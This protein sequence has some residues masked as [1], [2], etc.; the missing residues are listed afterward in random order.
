MMGKHRGKPN[1]IRYYCLEA[2]PLLAVITVT[3]LV[4][5]IGLAAS[6]WF[7]GQLVQR[8]L[9]I[10]QNQTP[11]NRM[12]PLAAA[13]ALT[14][15]FVQFTRFLKRLFVRKFANHINRSMKM[16][17]YRSLIRTSKAELSNQSVGAALTKSIA[18][19]DT[20]VEGIRKFTTE[21]FD[22]GIAFLTYFVMLMVYD[23][24]L[25]LIS[26]V[27]PPV[28]WFLAESM[29]HLASSAASAYKESTTALN[30]AT[31]DRIENAITYRV[32]GQDENRNRIYEGDLEDYER[33]AA[34]SGIL[35][36]SLQPVY[37][38]IA[39]LGAL[40]ILWLGGKNVAGTG[41][42]TWDIAAFTA[43]LSCFTKLSVK[44]SKIAKL[45]NSVQKARVSWKRVQP[46]LEDSEE[47]PKRPA[48]PAGDLEVRKLRFA[49]P[50]CDPLFGPVSFT[51]HP[52]QII[53]VT[54][55]VACGKSTLG[56]VFLCEYPY[57][58]AVLFGG[59]ELSRLIRE[60][61]GVVGYVGHDP[62]LLQDSIGENILLGEEGSAE[63][64][65]EAVC[66]LDEVLGMPQGLNTPMGS[67]REGLSGGQQ[68]RLA[69]ARALC[70]KR[71]LLIL[72]DPFSAVDQKTERI[73]FDNL[74]S[75]LP[76]TI[77]I[78]ISHRLSLFP[79]MDQV[80]WMDEGKIEVSTHE[81]LLDRNEKYAALFRA[82]TGKEAA[83]G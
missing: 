36:T 3:G 54:G 28:A 16:R 4:Y 67:S 30:N 80:L 44:S 57:E 47:I 1:T 64:Y 8:L 19:V 38:S 26:M 10:M 66:M 7:E 69:L 59:E 34:R 18:D 73:I 24:K 9:D 31:M 39:M 14:V 33:K 55:P 74:R 25:A 49:Y 77:I 83:V 5:N 45:F 23:W 48:E 22:T 70:N 17:L 2:L 20:C 51:A 56:R 68:A 72:D 71:P 53:G 58:G 13:Y 76:D 41:W 27:F 37:Q 11:P 61:R 32:Y 29:K 65:L 43:F 75:L 62:E 79:R 52:G 46:F 12:L 6:P 21:V 50:G 60:H 82:Q 42:T 15:L 35:E 78:L 40:F 63:P 81:A